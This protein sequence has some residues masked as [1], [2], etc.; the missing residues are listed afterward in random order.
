MKVLVAS[1]HEDGRLEVRGGADSAVLRCGEPVFI[2]EPASQWHSLAAPAVRIGRLGTNI[3]LKNARNYIDAVS[4]VHL[5]VPVEENEVPPFFCDRAISPGIWHDVNGFEAGSPVSL[6]VRICALPP[7]D[8]PARVLQSSFSIDAAPQI[9][10][11][12]SRRLTFKTGDIIVLAH[13]AVKLGEPVIDTS[14]DIEV[15]GKPTLSIRCK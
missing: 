4:A 8:S 2:E 15:A 3:S 1:L 12:I 10:S 6:A 7:Q 9:I 14:V 11:R 13:A 5:L